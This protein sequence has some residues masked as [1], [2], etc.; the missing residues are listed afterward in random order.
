VKT[1]EVE[2]EEE[3][4]EQAAA[5]PS[6]A[7]AP[8]WDLGVCPAAPPARA[9]LRDC[10]FWRRL[11]LSMR[12]CS[13]SPGISFPPG[14]F[15]PRFLA[16]WGVRWR[17]SVRACRLVLVLEGSRRGWCGVGA[18][19]ALG[20]GDFRGPVGSGWIAESRIGL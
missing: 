18:K 1:E 15:G 12:T 8:H 19:D 16:A 6:S 17:G 4:E 3:G 9:G 7:P 5:A 14:S 2:Q 10:L 20:L 11:L 13:L